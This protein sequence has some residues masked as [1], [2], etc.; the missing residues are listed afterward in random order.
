MS[1]FAGGMAILLDP[2]ML[3]VILSGTVLGVIV[4]AL[5][6]LSGS[7]TTALLLPLTI[8]MGPVPSVAFLGSIYCAAN[9]G[10]SITAILINTPGDPSAS[11]TAYDG[12]PMAK[13]GEAGRAL[14]ASVTAS[15]VGGI[16]GAIK[17]SQTKNAR[18][19]ET[20]TRYAMFDLEDIEGMIRAD[21]RPYSSTAIATCRAAAYP[22]RGSNMKEPT[23]L[24]G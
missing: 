10:G 3:W 5:P 11:A 7:T 22:A 2:Y 20:N 23:N 17:H 9:F 1:G 16:I 12:Y 21:P 24:S 19:G 15:G 4:G 8:G 6:G 18:A 13:K 14:G